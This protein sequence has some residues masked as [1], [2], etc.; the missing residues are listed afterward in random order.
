LELRRVAREE[1]DLTLGRLR[2]LPEA[3]I[4]RMA[5]SLAG[6]GQIE[7]V[8]AAEREGRLV[9][10]DGFIRC[11]G[12]ARVGLQE[13][14]VEVVELSDVEMK[15]QVYL[16]NRDRGLM[17]LEECRL[18]HELNRVDGLNQVEIGD[19]LER[20]KSWVCRRLS[21]YRTLSP[22]LRDDGMLWRL[23]GGSVRR[24]A[25]L[26]ERNQEELVAVAMR[27]T[28][29]PRESATLIDL[30]TK[31]ATPAG[32]SYLIEQPRE[33]IRNAE[34][35]QSP[36][37]DPRLGPAGQEVVNA[38]WG[39]ERLSLVLLRKTRAG[40]EVAAAEG[41]KLVQEAYERGSS[42]SKEALEAVSGW[43]STAEGRHEQ[44]GQEA[45]G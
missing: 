8:V 4:S 19:L 6:R 5:D 21:L 43:L 41:R 35:E 11:L 17:L 42:A 26:P 37:I 14:L 32:R 39:I 16:R 22:H 10:I 13:L 3:A 40:M 45:S 29:S 33:A 31:A 20:H 38:L 18:V 7:P 23:G 34:C 44:A 9:L 27:E 25:L 24:L 30:W 36:R 1:L 15:A 12:A 2:H 28:L